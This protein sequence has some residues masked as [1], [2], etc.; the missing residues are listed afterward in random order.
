MNNQPKLKKKHQNP[1][2]SMK[3]AI[4]SELFMGKE[5]IFFCRE[6]IFRTFVQ[7]FSKKQHRKWNTYDSP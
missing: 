1:S 7:S 5:S 2:F 3:C 4:P 6:W